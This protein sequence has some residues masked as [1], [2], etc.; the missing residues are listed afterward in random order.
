MT[1]EFPKSKTKI[2]PNKIQ[3]NPIYEQIITGIKQEFSTIGNNNNNLDPEIL[4][5]KYIQLKNSIQEEI[6]KKFEKSKYSSKISE[7]FEKNIEI[8]TDFF[9]E[10]QKITESGIS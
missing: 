9:I 1:N 3:E 8:L 6:S 4:T 5:E 10:C 2:K 7:I